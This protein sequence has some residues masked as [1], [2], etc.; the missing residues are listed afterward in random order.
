MFVE[1]RDQV[2][3]SR[4]IGDEMIIIGKD[5]NRC[6]ANI[7]QPIATGGKADVVVGLDQSIDH[8]CFVGAHGRESQLWFSVIEDVDQRTVFA[9]VVVNAANECGTANQAII[10]LSSLPGPGR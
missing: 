1:R 10:F 5:Y 4:L 7:E 8:C 2:G 3:Q 9:I 6:V